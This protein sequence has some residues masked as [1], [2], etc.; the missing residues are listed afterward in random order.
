MILLLSILATASLGSLSALLGATVVAV[1][2]L[3]LIGGHLKS[4]VWLASVMTLMAGLFFITIRQFPDILTK[5][6]HLT[7]DRAAH[8]ADERLFLWGG[9]T[10]VLFSPRSI[11]GVGPNNYRDFLENKTLH[12]DT[13]EFGVERGVIGLLGL[14]LLA[15]EALISAVKILLNQI[16]SRD[17]AQPS[18]VIFLA[19]LFGVLLESNAH[20]IFHFRSVWLGMALLEATFYKMLSPS[21]ELATKRVKVWGEKLQLPKKSSLSTD[22]RDPPSV[23]V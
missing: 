10:E 4:F 22:R 21:I 15:G 17:T 11:L 9:G 6:E 19:M 23:E 7:T 8:T 12:N 20:Q 1:F 14:V 3:L 18:G 13:L 2:L 5:L 16:K